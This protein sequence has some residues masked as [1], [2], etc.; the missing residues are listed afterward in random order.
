MTLHQAQVEF[1]RRLPLLIEQAYALGFE[2]VMGECKRSPE[3]AE[4]LSKTGAGIKNS[5]HCLSLAVD[6]MLFKDGQWLKLTEQ[7]TPLGQYWESLS[8]HEVEC[9][10][11][12]RFPSRPDGGH[13]SIAWNGTK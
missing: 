2:V 4:R 13:F 3:E 10:W 5:L 8:T 11:G 6:L 9:A 1:S 7:Y 12:G